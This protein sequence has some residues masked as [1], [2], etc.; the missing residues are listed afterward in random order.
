MLFELWCRG[1]WL[2]HSAEA[3]SSYQVAL[4]VHCLSGLQAPAL[5]AFQYQEWPWHPASAPGT[6]QSHWFPSALPVSLS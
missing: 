3:D 6:T 1:G 2:P 5:L 4:S